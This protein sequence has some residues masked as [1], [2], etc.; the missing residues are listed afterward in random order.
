MFRAGSMETENVQGKKLPVKNGGVCIYCGSDG[1]ADGLGSEHI[2]PFSLG[3]NT[4]LLNASCRACEGITSYLDGYLAN[5]VFGDFRVHM[6]LQS[7]IR[8]CQGWSKRHA[9]LSSHCWRSREA[10]LFFKAANT[11][12]RSRNTAL[13]QRRKKSRLCSES[14]GHGTSQS[15]EGS[16]C[17]IFHLRVFASSSY[18]VSREQGWRGIAD[19]PKLGF[20]GTYAI[21]IIAERNCNG[22][23]A[24]QLDASPGSLS[25]AAFRR[26]P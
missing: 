7:R 8:P 24:G 3:G 14:S 26:T 16:R 18:A 20:G 25:V 10:T 22:Q 17:S 11:N 19:H 9:D 5:A 23:S 2:I 1:G 15:P 6:D 4:E 12:A 13:T 21:D